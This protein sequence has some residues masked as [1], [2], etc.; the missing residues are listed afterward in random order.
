MSC[1]S[2]EKIIAVEARKYS[3]KSET[4]INLIK[5]LEN[6]G[7]ILHHV[8]LLLLTPDCIERGIYNDIIDFIIAQTGAT[9]CSAR[10]LQLDL[11]SVEELY[12][13]AIQKKM[14][15]REKVY[16]WL[17]EKMM[18]QGPAMILLLYCNNH[19]EDFFYQTVLRLKKISDSKTA[20]IRDKFVSF[21]KVLNIVHSPDDLHSFL[22]EAMV[23]FQEEELVNTFNSIPSI[24]IETV[25]N[26][27]SGYGVKEELPL[28]IQSYFLDRI[29]S[30]IDILLSEIMSAKCKSALVMRK[31]QKI[32]DLQLIKNNINSGNIRINLAKLSD[33][34]KSLDVCHTQWEM[35]FLLN[36]LLFGLAE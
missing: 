8:G 35:I 17:L 16:L 29:D 36:L 14:A 26:L 10:I 4:N 3:E 21:G 13:N 31:K 18:S 7:M 24:P 22:S 9:I 20:S 11:Y 34:L 28:K 15:A 23:F 2:L 32:E 19:E 33:E 25:K 30:T 6:H 27:L 1:T 12:K 5:K